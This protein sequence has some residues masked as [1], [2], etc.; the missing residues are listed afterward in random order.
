MKEGTHPL[1]IQMKPSLAVIL[2]MRLTMPSEVLALMILV[3]MTSTGLQTVV[4][5]KPAIKDAEKCV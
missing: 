2:V 4:A 3:L 1:N 5:T